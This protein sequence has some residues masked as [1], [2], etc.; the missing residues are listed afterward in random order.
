MDGCPQRF[1]GFQY[2]IGAGSTVPPCTTE[3]AGVDNKCTALL[4]TDGPVG[5]AVNHAVGFRKQAPEVQF[6]VVSE[7]RAMGQADGKIIELKGFFPWE[8][9]TGT[10]IAHISMHGVRCKTGK[11]I[12]HFDVR[13]V[14]GVNNDVT[15]RKAVINEFVEILAGCCQMCI[16][17][18]S[19]LHKLNVVLKLSG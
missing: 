3:A 18:Y 12:E 5:V 10:H 8:S 7:M 4:V 16:G 1:T 13:Q 14:T 6:N 9:R 19:C 2:G 17:K 15:G 11:S